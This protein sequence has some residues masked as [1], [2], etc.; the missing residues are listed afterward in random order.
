MTQI[1]CDRV[2]CVHN[3]HCVCQVKFVKL[4]WNG[5]DN[6]ICNKIEPIGR[7]SACCNQTPEFYNH[8]D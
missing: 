2:D 7:V 4:R 1:Q 6:F 3:D 8:G 5:A